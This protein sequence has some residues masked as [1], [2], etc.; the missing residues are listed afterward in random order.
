MTRPPPT[1]KRTYTLL[2][3]AT[4]FRSNIRHLAVRR[5]LHDADR[6][7]HAQL[8]AA[9]QRRNVPTDEGQRLQSLRLRPVAQLARREHDGR[10]SE[11]RF[12]RARRIGLRAGEYRAV[13]HAP[14]H[15]VVDVR[16]RLVVHEVERSDEPTSDLQSLMRISYA[17]FCFT[18][19]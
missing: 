11:D 15:L 12:E 13:Q 9:S 14:R 2:P 18:H 3:H 6:G 19:K 10:L 5:R 4:L 1:H 7:Q 17:A 8:V 16:A